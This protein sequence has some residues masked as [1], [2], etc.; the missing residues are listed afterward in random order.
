MTFSAAA[1]DDKVAVATTT[2]DSVG[3]DTDVVDKQRP[4][5]SPTGA[6]IAEPKIM[7]AT[8]ERVARAAEALREAA[9]RRWER[10]WVR[11]EGEEDD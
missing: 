9:E 3:V 2:R 1:A 6:P 5:E 7:A 11:E 4:Q 8:T 10:R